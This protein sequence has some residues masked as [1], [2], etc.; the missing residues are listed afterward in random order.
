MPL[1]RRFDGE[2]VK[3]IDPVRR[4]MTLV[5][6]A[7]NQSIIYHTTQWDVTKAR[8]WL[9]AYNRARGA[10]SQA[11]LFHLVAYAG[12]RTFYA[13]P[14]L[15]RFVSGGRI[16]QRKGM[17]LS[18]TVKTGLT[19]GAPLTTIKLNFPENERF[20]EVVERI[21]D[22]VKNVRSGKESQFERE[23][24]FFAGLPGPLL[25]VIYA[26]TRGLDR[27]NLLPAFL[28]KP[29]PNY[30]SLFLV[31]LGSI[32]LD[33][34]YHHL[35]EYGT[36][37]LFGVVGRSKSVTILDHRGQPQVR[38]VMQVHWSF[39]ERVNDGFYCMKSLEIGGRIIEDPGRYIELGAARVPGCAE[40]FEASETVTQG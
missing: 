15:N 9:R 31:D 12:V 39:D 8:A 4:M 21:T 17:W 38:Q 28:I 26:F 24:R 35:Y 25:Q 29:D 6:R 33:N 11:T 34:A 18:S 30:T 20:D 7:R 23:V 27:V 3:D 5:M 2:L 36:C 1:F 22:A 19:D 37:G 16:Y 13:K 10:K 32:H 14:G 40:N